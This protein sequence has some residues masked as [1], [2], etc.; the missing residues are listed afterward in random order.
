MIITWVTMGQINETSVEYGINKL[1]QIEIGNSELFI[2]GGLERRKMQIH[3]VQLS[4][5][6]PGK[7]YSNSNNKIIYD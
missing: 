4:G 1:D 6:T 5:L 7:S 3:R 2:D